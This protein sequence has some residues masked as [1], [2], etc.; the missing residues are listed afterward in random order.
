MK[1]IDNFK[2]ED[3]ENVYS[4][5]SSTKPFNLFGETF[6]P[7]YN[8]EGKYRCHSASYRNLVIKITGGRLTIENSLHKF[9]NS[10]NYSD[11]TFSEL[12]NAIE[13]IESKLKIQSE[14]LKLKRIEVAVNIEYLEQF[15]NLFIL[16]GMKE[17]DNMRSGKTIYGKK[18]FGSEFNV[19]GYDKTIETKLNREY[20]DLGTQIKAPDNVSFP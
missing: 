19:K 14:H 9:I 7:R 2:A 6:Y 5:P 15:N 8:F 3:V 12:N 20:D 13:Q 16:Y 1:M 18:F 11:F 4:I 17:F 10:N